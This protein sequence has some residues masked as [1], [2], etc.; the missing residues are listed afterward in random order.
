MVE[1]FT[2]FYMVKKLLTFAL[3]VNIQH[4]NSVNQIS[5]ENFY[6]YSIT[7]LNSVVNIYNYCY[8]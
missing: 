4:S 7:T 1:S 6:L 8:R 2:Q 5:S 3:E